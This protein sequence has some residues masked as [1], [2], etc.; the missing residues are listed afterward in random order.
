MARPGTESPLAKTSFSGTPPPKLAPR[1]VSSFPAE[2]EHAPL[3]FEASKVRAGR[4]DRISVGVKDSQG[5]SVPGFLHLPHGF[6][7]D[8]SDTA[9]SKTAV[10]LLSGAGGGV[11]GPSGI[12]LSI[13]D[14][15]SS[16]A[17]LAIPA[18]RLDYRYPAR[19]KYCCADV[20][21]AMDHLTAAYPDHISRFVL[22]GWSFG[23]APVLT[24]GGSDQRVIGCAT[25]ASQTAE[26]EGVTSLPPRPLLLLHGTGDRTLSPICSKRLYEWYGSKGD[27]QLKLYDGDDHALTRN[28]KEAEEMIVRFI[29][30]CAGVRMNEL[31]AE[32]RK[33]L[34]DSLI[35]NVKEA[36]EVMKKGGD[37][38]G[39]ERL[40]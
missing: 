22:V 23:G 38:D 14:K 21:A 28:S 10:I 26:T 4:V 40:K 27:R 1:T 6:A 2:V 29:A 13:A 25:I 32:E 8:S 3:L 16:I 18:L 39:Q 35:G 31:D 5:G 24:V 9:A 20:M 34:D 7:S 30:R 11:T 17:H 33:V 37:L 12:Y 19:N 15:L 36:V